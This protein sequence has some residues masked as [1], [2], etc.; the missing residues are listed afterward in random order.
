MT[1]VSDNPEPVGAVF[2]RRS[3]Q[4]QQARKHVKKLTQNLLVLQKA[5]MC[6]DVTLQCQIGTV[7]AHSGNI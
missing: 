2:S 5:G 7:L 3:T 6:C 1:S 4:E